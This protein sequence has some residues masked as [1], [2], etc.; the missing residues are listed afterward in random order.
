MKRQRVTLEIDFNEKL[1][2]K[3]ADWNW[4]EVTDTNPEYIRLISSE[5]VEEAK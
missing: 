3:P 1:V 5:P 4:A 2:D